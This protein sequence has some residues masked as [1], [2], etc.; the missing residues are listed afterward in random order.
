MI[1]ETE[2]AGSDLTY[3]L[4]QGGIGSAVPHSHHHVTSLY[5]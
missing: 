4:A 3:V 2:D 5:L 1:V